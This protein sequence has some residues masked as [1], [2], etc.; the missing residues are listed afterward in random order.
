MAS[1]ALVFLTTARGWLAATA[2]TVLAVA[3]LAGAGVRLLAGWWSDRVG[4]RCARCGCS[5]W[6][7]PPTSCC[8]PSGRP[9]HRRS[10]PPPCCSPP[11]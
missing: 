6:P 7:P 9:P 5:P 8:S 11:H 4:S 3:N 1:F 2:G 10:A